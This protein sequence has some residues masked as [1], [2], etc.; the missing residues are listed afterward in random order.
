VTI[1]EHVEDD[2]LVQTAID[3]LPPTWETFVLGVCAR[4]NQRIF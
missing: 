2:D 3:S 1:R 4:E